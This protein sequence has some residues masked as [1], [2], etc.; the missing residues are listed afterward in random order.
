MIDKQ[1]YLL[2]TTTRLLNDNFKLPKLR[3]IT[4]FWREKD[5]TVCMSYYFD[6]PISDN[7]F[8]DVNDLDGGIIAQFTDAMLE[9]S[10]IRLDFPKPLPTEFLAYKRDE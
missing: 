7:D 5:H 3:A 2:F 9:E 10:F 8:D 6:G 4:A 1:K